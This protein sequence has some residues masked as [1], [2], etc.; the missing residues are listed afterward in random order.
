MLSNV[1][2]SSHSKAGITVQRVKLLLAMTVSHF[3]D[4]AQQQADWLLIQLSAKKHP[5]RQQGMTQFLDPCHP[6]ENLYC[7]PDCWLYQAQ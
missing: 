2:Q 3:G 7:V 1:E 5:V 6:H 4:L